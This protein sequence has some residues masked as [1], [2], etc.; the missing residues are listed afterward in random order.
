MVS[1]EPRKREQD[2][3]LFHP[4]W[5]GMIGWYMNRIFVTLLGTALLIFLSSEN[6]IPLVLVILFVLCLFLLV[7]G[8]GRLKRQFTIY[9]VTTRQISETTGIFSKRTESALFSDITNTT[10]TQRFIERIFGVGGLQFDTAGEHLI[11]REIARPSRSN[12]TFLSWWGVPDPHH[13]ISVIDEQRF[14][15]GEEE[16]S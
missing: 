6:V 9:R 4:S 14:G 2:V 1:P 15:D 13:V 16:S 5:K 7:F 12:L 8:I 10:V 11:T 3:L